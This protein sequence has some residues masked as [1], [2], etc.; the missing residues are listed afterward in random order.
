MIKEIAC[1]CGG[2][3]SS[4]ELLV[5]DR[6]KTVQKKFYLLNKPLPSKG[7]IK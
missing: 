2:T 6:S 4:P 3:L 5:F 1:T 7:D